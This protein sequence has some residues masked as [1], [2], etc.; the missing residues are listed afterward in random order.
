M[1]EEGRIAKA[2]FLNHSVIAT[3][4]HVYATHDKHPMYMYM[5]KHAYVEIETV[6]TYGS[7]KC[8]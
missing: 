6:A 2:K 7:V 3:Y 5:N 1:A 8:S 4:V